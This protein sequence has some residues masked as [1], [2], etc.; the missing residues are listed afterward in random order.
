MSSNFICLILTNCE[1]MN[2]LRIDKINIDIIVYMDKKTLTHLERFKRLWVTEEHKH[3]AQNNKAYDKRAFASA[4]NF[5]TTNLFRELFSFIQH[6]SKNVLYHQYIQYKNGLVVR[7][8]M[9]VS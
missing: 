1:N 8:I 5:I 9:H 6:S 3:K 7:C 4:T 2:I